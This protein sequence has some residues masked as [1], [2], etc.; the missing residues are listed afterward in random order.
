MSAASSSTNTGLKIALIVFVTL[1]FILAT[2]TYFGFKGKFDAET[3]ARTQKATADKTA[4]DL[5]AAQ[6]NE[7][8]LRDK[9]GIAMVDPDD[10]TKVDPGKAIDAWFA[11]RFG[12]FAED[13][14]SYEKL[15]EWLQKA[16]REKD[17]QLKTLLI[18]KDNRIAALERD[19][20]Q[21]DERVE[22]F[23]K[24]SEDAK[25]DA[26]KQRQDFAAFRKT[27]E[28]EKEDINEKYK[29]ALEK[30]T[31]LESIEEAVARAQDMVSARRL[32]RFKSQSA[33]ERVG[34][35]LDELRERERAI[36]DSNELLAKLRVADPALQKTVTDSIPLDDRIDGFDG[37]IVSID[38]ADRTVL[39]L[40]ESTR[41]MR[42]GL[43]LLVFG[44]DDPTPQIVRKKAVVEVMAIESPTLV[45][46]RIRED[47]L[48]DPIL[49]GDG[50]ATSLW[51][52]GTQFTS[53]IVGFVQ[54]ERDAA[55]D[56]DRLTELIERVGGR[57]EDAVNPLTTMVI[58]AGAPQAAGDD[59]ARGWKEKDQ[60]RRRRQLDEAKRLGVRVIGIDQF[61][62]M[63]GLR[64]DS[65]DANRLPDAAATR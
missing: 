56:T 9:I 6:A 24:E 13:P 39:I 35:M 21:R 38:Q 4:E 3:Q 12:D 53:V 57:V 40:A 34:T 5:R 23:R 10:P 60:I 20:K 52:A 30:A 51:E 17:G 54:I 44:P 64:R 65:L 42:T 59:K 41:G 43:M 2:T 14:R 50:V 27:N 46:A 55:P 18:E 47:S 16:V 58:D 33:E 62:Q 26:A 48:G 45:R 1:T 8:L 32:D 37:R 29:Q 63:L 22:A 25:A 11:E 28:Q 49:P 15:A 36:N 19:I 61:M 31:Q 7:Q